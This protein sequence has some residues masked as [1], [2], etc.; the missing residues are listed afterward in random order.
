MVAIVTMSFND[1][2]DASRIITESFDVSPGS[3]IVVENAYGNITVDTWN[4]NKVEF[5]ITISARSGNDASSKR[6]VDETTVDFSKSGNKLYAI[7]KLTEKKYKKSWWNFWKSDN[8]S[9]DVNYKIMMPRS[10]DLDFKNKYGD[11]ILGQYDG[12]LDT[13]LSYGNLEAENITSTTDLDI[14]YGKVKFAG[15]KNAAID[16]AYGDLIAGD[17]G[18]LEF[19]SKYS[20]I[21]IESAMDMTIYSKYDDYVLGDVGKLINEGA[22][23]DFLIRSARSIILDTRYTDLDAKSLEVNMD[24]DAAYGEIKI[25]NI[26]HAFS[27]GNIVTSYTEIEL[28]FSGDVLLDINTARTEVDLGSQYIEDSYSQENR[29]K[30]ISARKGKG[31]NLLKAKMKYGSLEIN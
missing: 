22:Y 16:I 10:M 23:D 6:F 31:G 14:K 9:I 5:T 2:D 24:I 28:S 27:E 12:S 3:T 26:S 20:D 8:Q 13:E 18:N 7:T 4:Q 15:L 25:G 30:K 17:C 19:H 21:N 1:R 11:I 29:R